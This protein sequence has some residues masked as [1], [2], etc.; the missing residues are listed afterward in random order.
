MPRE[1]Y[2]FLEKVTGI[3]WVLGLAED[4][5][6]GKAAAEAV[7]TQPVRSRTVPCGSKQGAVGHVC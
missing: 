2:I 4:G 6:L 5:S 1:G 3:G 7:E